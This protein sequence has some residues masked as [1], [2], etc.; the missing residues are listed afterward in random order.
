MPNTL[1]VNLDT[2]TTPWSV[3]VDD[4]NNANHVAQGSAEQ[5]IT[6][7]LNGNAAN[8]TFMPLTDPTHPGFSWVGTQPPAGV[9]SKAAV[10]GNTFT[11]HD[12]NNNANAAGTWTYRLC[13][14]VGGTVYTTINTSPA[15]KNT[16][17]TSKNN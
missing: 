7:Q 13:I 4:G 12:L 17:P 2:T 3:N 14:N 11:L 10:N 6:W 8:G 1:Y 5:V 15:A 9:F 16:N